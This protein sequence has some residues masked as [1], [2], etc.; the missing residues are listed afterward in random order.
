[1]ELESG[2]LG[3]EGR[4]LVSKLG[5]QSMH[6]LISWIGEKNSFFKTTLIIQHLFQSTCHLADALPDA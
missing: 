6:K 3:K 2:E 5:L 1:M 4:G